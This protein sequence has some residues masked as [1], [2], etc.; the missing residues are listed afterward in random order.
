[1]ERFIALLPSGL[2]FAAG[3][4]AYVAVF[5]LLM[6][7]VEDAD[8]LTAGGVGAAACAAMFAAQTLLK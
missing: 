2:G 1:M 8:V 4:M 3:A 7:A 6:E 5:E